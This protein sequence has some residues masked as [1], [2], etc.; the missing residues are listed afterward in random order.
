M[1]DRVGELLFSS[2]HCPFNSNS[3]RKKCVSVASR[4]SVLQP[5]VYPHCTFH[6]I[7]QL[8]LNNG[9]AC[10][11][12]S[13]ESLQRTETLCLRP[14]LPVHPPPTS[15]PACTLAAMS[16]FLGLMNSH[17]VCQLCPFH[18]HFQDVPCSTLQTSLVFTWFGLWPH[19]WRDSNVRWRWT[20]ELL[21]GHG[22][23]DWQRPSS[24][25]GPEG[26]PL[27]F[28]RPAHQSVGASVQPPWA[29]VWGHLGC[30][31]HCL[32]GMALTLAFYPC[33]CFLPTAPLLSVSCVSIW[34]QGQRKGNFRH[35]LCLLGAQ[36]LWWRPTVSRDM[37]WEVWEQS[38]CGW[39]WG[40]GQPRGAQGRRWRTRSMQSEDLVGC[41]SMWRCRWQP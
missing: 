27:G 30:V 31:L 5:F 28:C 40:W 20:Q 32:K 13:S 12:S 6:L 37:T 18:F 39:S 10:K 8:C 36:G 19:R 3:V 24:P 4:F 29:V 14:C 35:W 11:C 2:G 25:C 34:C 21:C 9:E 15:V 23:G 7:S 33:T 16:I 1:A 17:P 26:H 41:D 38:D 22:R